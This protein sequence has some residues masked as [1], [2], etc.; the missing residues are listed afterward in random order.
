[1]QIY[2]RDSLQEAYTAGDKE[3]RHYRAYELM[4]VDLSRYAVPEGYL[5]RG[6]A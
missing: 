3:L 5:A 4:G 2:Y 1:M 6:E